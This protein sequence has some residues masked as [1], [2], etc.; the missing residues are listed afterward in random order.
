MSISGTSTRDR[1][2]SLR[3]GEYQQYDPAMLAREFA[4]AFPWLKQGLIATT[5][6]GAAACEQRICQ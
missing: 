1:P 5:L 4:S 2:V 3:I 6:G